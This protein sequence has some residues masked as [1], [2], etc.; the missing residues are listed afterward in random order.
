MQNQFR[1]Q[2]NYNPWTCGNHSHVLGQV[3]RGP[4]GVTGLSLYRQA[5]DV[6]AECPVDVDVIG[7]LT[8]DMADISCSICGATRTWFS[9][10]DAMER[11]IQRAQRRRG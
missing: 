5:V 8:G 2:Q 9:G 1:N 11:I 7:L 10:A 4:D 3:V 6:T